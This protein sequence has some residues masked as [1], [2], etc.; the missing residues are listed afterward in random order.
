MKKIHSLFSN[1]YNYL[2]KNWMK[3]GL[4]VIL[5]DPHQHSNAKIAK[6]DQ[7]GMQM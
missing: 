5:D 2:L 4:V 7:N 3:S 1:M 6:D